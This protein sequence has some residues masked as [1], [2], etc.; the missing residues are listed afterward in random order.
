MDV[1]SLITGLPGLIIACADLYKMTVTHRHRERD[2]NV[3]IKRIA[4]EQSKFA[5]L[6]QG[7]GFVEGGKPMLRLTPAVQ[8][9]LL[10][11]LQTIEGTYRHPYI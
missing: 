7:V 4:F 6:L 1:T 8:V 10:H 11:L 9:M 3:V 5:Y 2:I